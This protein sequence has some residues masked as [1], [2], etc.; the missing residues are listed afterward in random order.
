MKRIT[1]SNC[2]FEHDR[3]APD[4]NCVGDSVI[5]DGVHI[6]GCGNAIKGE[7]N[8]LIGVCEECV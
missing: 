5:L 4:H 7:S 1:C 6:C 8:Q 2:G 3:E